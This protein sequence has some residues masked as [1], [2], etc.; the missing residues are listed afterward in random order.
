[1]Q[2]YL[3]VCVRV[4]VCV[5][6]DMCVFRALKSTRVSTRPPLWQQTTTTKV[7]PI[8]Q[9]RVFPNSKFAAGVQVEQGLGDVRLTVIVSQH[10]S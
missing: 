3:C 7:R 2:S 8:Q 1:M 6:V 5:C 9:K 4:C 10:L